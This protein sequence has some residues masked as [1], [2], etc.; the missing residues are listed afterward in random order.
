M[1]RLEFFTWKEPGVPTWLAEETEE[2][3]DKLEF[4]GYYGAASLSPWRL[5]L[6]WKT[7][8]RN[9]RGRIWVQSNRENIEKFLGWLLEEI[10][11]ERM[12]IEMDLG[13]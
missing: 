5:Y 7:F 13:E 10:P 11:K 9:S 2:L 8:S 12:V 6:A 4:A 1:T 3:R